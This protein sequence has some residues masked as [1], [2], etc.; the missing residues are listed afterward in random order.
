MQI[1]AWLQQGMQQARRKTFVPCLPDKDHRAETWNARDS[2]TSKGVV[3]KKKFESA[4][5]L[6]W[7]VSD[8]EWERI[9]RKMFDEGFLG[10]SQAE[11]YY[12]FADGWKQELAK[13]RIKHR[14]AGIDDRLFLHPKARR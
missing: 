8:E 2:E 6:H 9:R 1:L 3:M 14:R 11:R 7:Q 12:W 4:R 5:D 10:Y 13:Q